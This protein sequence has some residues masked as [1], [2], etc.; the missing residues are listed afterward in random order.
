[1]APPNSNLCSG[2]VFGGDF[3]F[4][5]SIED[6]VPVRANDGIFQ[7]AFVDGGTVGQKVEVKD[8]RVSAGF[9]VRLAIPMLGPAPIAPDFAFPSVKWS[10]APGR[11]FS[12]WMGHFS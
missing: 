4:L 3:L 5:N 1:V 10:E 11:L 9:G 2:F 8:Y 12:F 6:Q 7:D